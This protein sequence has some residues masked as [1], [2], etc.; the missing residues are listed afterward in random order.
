MPWSSHQPSR[1]R[2]VN[3]GPL[4]QRSDFG[5]TRCSIAFSRARVTA[6]LEIPVATSISGH[7]RVKLS[8]TV[9]ARIAQPL[10]QAVGNEVHRPFPI[11]RHCACSGGNRPDYALTLHPPQRETLFAIQPVNSFHIHLHTP[12]LRQNDPQPPIAE[13]RVLPRFR[14]QRFA[15]LLVPVRARIVPVTRPFDVKEPAS[16]AFAESILV[17]QQCHVPA[18]THKPHPFFRITAF[19]ASLPRLRSATISLRRRFSSSS[20]LRRFAS[21]TS[22][23][24]Y[25]DFQLYSVW[26]V[27]PN[28]RANSFTGRPAS[29]CFTT[30]MIFSSVCFVFFISKA[31]FYR[32]FPNYD[33]LSFSGAGQEEHGGR[34]SVVT[35]NRGEARRSFA[36]A[37]AGEDLPPFRRRVECADHVRM[38]G[39]MRRP[40]RS[41]LPLPERLCV[42]FQGGRSRR[43]AGESAGPESAAYPK[44]TNL[45][46]CR[47]SG[48]SGC[49][50]RLHADAGTRRTEGVPERLQGASAGRCLCRLR[51]LL[52]RSGTRTCGGWLLGACAAPL[53]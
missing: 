16:P 32:N 21:L 6:W 19:S 5:R 39:A 13:A 3:S 51:Q 15:Q 20:D 46:V 1:C 8:T 50:L 38:D 9:R 7:S 30:P 2:L 11:R 34:E 25:F 31:P 49:D 23:P 14:H 53:P 33:W 27:T 17:H 4:S 36:A 37:P 40:A 52:H 24:P 28:S 47:R 35:G 26:S 22:I 29:I 43:Y 48:S 44:R 12:L 42:V 18:R 10:C 41:S 45:A